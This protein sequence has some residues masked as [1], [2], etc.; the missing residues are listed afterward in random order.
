M[1]VT[2]LG[3]AISRNEEQPQNALSPM[4]V[5]EFGMAISRNERQ[6]TN[7]LKPMFVTEFGM[8]ISC[9]ELHHENALS[10]IIFVPSFILYCSISHPFNNLFPSLLYFAPNSSVT[11]SA[12][13]SFVT[14]V[15]S[16]SSSMTFGFRGFST[17]NRRKD[18]CERFLWVL[19]I[20]K[21][22]TRVLMSGDC[23]GNT[24]F[25]EGTRR[26][27]TVIAF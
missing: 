6:P 5:T 10:Q 2:E 25:K 11:A 24:S 17:A 21:R 23:E 22:L 14:L 15:E 3:M 19:A 16:T 1:L 18:T 12:K 26:K 9:N 8:A 4:L 13:S 20:V 27:V 7:A